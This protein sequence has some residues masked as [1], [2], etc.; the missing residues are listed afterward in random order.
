MGR[1]MGLIEKEFKLR[2]E[3][4]RHH[5]LEALIEIN[6]AAAPKWHRHKL[7]KASLKEKRALISFMGRIPAGFL[8]W[9]KDFYSHHFIDLVIVHPQMRRKGVAQAMLKAMESICPGNKL[10]SSTNKNNVAMQEVFRQGGF[11]K[12]G[13]I[14]HLDKGNPELI[15]YKKV[16]PKTVSSKPR[17]RPRP[18]HKRKRSKRR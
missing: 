4:A 11:V 1:R 3:T 15:Y 18:S 14:S 6:K 13:Y 2:V 7:L 5:H 16:P 10:F 17:R 8:V 12:A 9:T